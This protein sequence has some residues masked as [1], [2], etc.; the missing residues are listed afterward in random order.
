M[1]ISNGIIPQLIVLKSCSN[2]QDLTSLQVCNEKKNFFVSDISEVGFW[3]FWLMLP[4]LGP[5]C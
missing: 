4:G 3:P 2:P 5:I 1:C